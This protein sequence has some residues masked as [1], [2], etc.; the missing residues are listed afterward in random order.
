M[1]KSTLKAIIFICLTLLAITGVFVTKHFFT[2]AILLLIAA[3]MVK[4]D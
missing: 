1:K 3:F 2:P 4:E